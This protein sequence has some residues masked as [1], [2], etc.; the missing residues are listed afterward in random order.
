MF[1]G[2]RCSGGFH[3]C[4]SASK[5]RSASAHAA[6]GSVLGMMQRYDES[7]QHLRR[8]VQLNPRDH[9]AWRNLAMAETYSTAS[10]EAELRRLLEAEYD[11][12]AGLVDRAVVGARSTWSNRKAS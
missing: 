12:N 9:E 4:G 5:R 2:E 11:G 8:A 3:P 1:S 6:Y 10:D 7:A